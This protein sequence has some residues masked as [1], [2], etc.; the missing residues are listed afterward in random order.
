MIFIYCCWVFHRLEVAGELVQKY[1]MDRYMYTK[2]KTVHKTIKKHRI[3][4]TGK[5]T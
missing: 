5:Q 1:E 2:E 4:K 3:H